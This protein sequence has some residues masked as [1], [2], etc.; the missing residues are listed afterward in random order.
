[1]THSFSREDDA[2]QSAIQQSL[3]DIAAQMGEPITLEI[4][5]QLY[6]EAV[7]LLSHVDYAPIT[8]ARVAG[9]LLVYQ[10][11]NIEPEELKWFKTQIKQTTEAEEVEELIESMSRE[12]L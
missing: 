8:L 6:Q 10:L 9:T 11:Q 3:Q 4:A 2:I 1:M 5:A 7:D 12:A